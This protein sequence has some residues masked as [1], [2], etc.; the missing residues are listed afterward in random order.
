[1]IN[2]KFCTI[3][4]NFLTFHGKFI[5]SDDKYLMSVTYFLGVSLPG[6][7]LRHLMKDLG[8]DVILTNE[9]ETFKELHTLAQEHIC[10]GPSM[11]FKRLARAGTTKIRNTDN[12]V[13]S[14]IGLDCNS[15]YLSTFLGVSFNASC[16]CVVLYLL[17]T[18][19]Y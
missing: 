10:G 4:S 3:D 1:M 8:N 6:L 9:S 17:F 12:K 2:S 18:Q 11:A 16:H 15:L 14:V 7:A 19:I 13:G 5:K